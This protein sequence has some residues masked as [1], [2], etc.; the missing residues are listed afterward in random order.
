M[1]QYSVVHLMNGNNHLDLC[2]I[3]FQ[4]MGSIGVLVLRE[5]FTGESWFTTN[6]LLVGER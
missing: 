3:I 4:P 2:N 6:Y 1:R 5:P